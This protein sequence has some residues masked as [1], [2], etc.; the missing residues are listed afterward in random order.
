MMQRPISIVDNI[1][2][3]S[4]FLNDDVIVDFGIA[5]VIVLGV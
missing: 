4:K 2:A 1:E 5:A 3:Q